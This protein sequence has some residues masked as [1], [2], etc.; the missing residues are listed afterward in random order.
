[1]ESTGGR[2]FGGVKIPR[3]VIF[4]SDGWRFAPVGEFQESEEVR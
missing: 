3:V 2:K 1:M 4:E